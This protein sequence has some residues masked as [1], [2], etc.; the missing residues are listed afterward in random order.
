MT[1]GHNQLNLFLLTLAR[2]YTNK[3]QRMSC[4]QMKTPA[5]DNDT[6]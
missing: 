5:A 6:F 4:N 1:P 2:F 3:P